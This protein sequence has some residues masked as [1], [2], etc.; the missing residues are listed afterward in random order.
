M[1]AL[2]DESPK[3]F[4]F[5]QGFIFREGELGAKEKIGEGVFVQEAVNHDVSSFDV[6]VESPV[7]CAKTVKED[8]MAFHFS[9]TFIVEGFEVFLGDLEFVEEFQ[10]FECAEL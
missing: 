5:G 9:K 8:A 4:G 2:V 1:T 10:L 7:A 3:M 6:E